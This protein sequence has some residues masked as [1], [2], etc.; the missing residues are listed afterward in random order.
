MLFLLSLLL[1][2]SYIHCPLSNLLGHFFLLQEPRVLLDRLTQSWLRRIQLLAAHTGG[3]QGQLGRLGSTV[4]FIKIP[5]L[6]SSLP[7][8]VFEKRAYTYRYVFSFIY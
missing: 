1:P 8:N 2:S 4:E 3:D 6:N 5:Q 7:L